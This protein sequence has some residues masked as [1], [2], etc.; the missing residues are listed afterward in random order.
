MLLQ[1][2]LEAE[3][4]SFIITQENTVAYQDSQIS[5]EQTINNT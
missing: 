5:Q 1:L 3:Y 4:I 2:Y